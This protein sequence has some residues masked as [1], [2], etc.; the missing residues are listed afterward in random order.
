MYDQSRPADNRPPRPRPATR[1]IA[2]PSDNQGA[3]WG[4]SNFGT[5]S[6][7]DSQPRSSDFLGLSAKTRTVVAHLGPR[8][9]RP[10][11]RATAAL[12]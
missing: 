11:A 4:V 2:G 1:T 6:P 3:K 10:R 7:F 9:A 12:A 5:L 8:A